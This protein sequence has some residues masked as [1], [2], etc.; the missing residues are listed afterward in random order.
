MNEDVEDSQL[1]CASHLLK[2]YWIILA[3]S[4]KFDRIEYFKVKRTLT[5]KIVI[6]LLTLY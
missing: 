5:N 2:V 6:F 3:G 1:C 4:S